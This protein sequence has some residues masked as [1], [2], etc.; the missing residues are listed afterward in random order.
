VPIPLHQKRIDERGFNQAMLI[1]ET[2]SKKRNY[3]IC[4]LLK[5]TKETKQQ[6]L[7]NKKERK[8]N[9]SNI[10]EIDSNELNK[11]GSKN[12]ILVD[13]IIT[14]GETLKSAAL[15]IKN[16]IPNKLFAITLSRGIK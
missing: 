13:D 11:L 1:C 10:F 16:L 2:I 3:A 9:V 15:T 7:L 14:S 5:R 12:I 4:H 8:D 6:A